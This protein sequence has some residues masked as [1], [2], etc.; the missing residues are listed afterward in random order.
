MSDTRNEWLDRLCTLNAAK[1]A[2]RG[3]APH[4]PLLLLCVM[5]MVEEGALLSPW[6]AYSPELFFR[7]QCYWEI[8]YDRQ[9]NRPDMRLPFHHLGSDRIWTCYE[10]DRSPS[11]SKETTRLCCIDESLW[12]C[13]RDAAFRRDARVRLITAYFTP[14]EQI[15]LCARLRLPEPTTEAIEAI[16][17]TA[18]AYKA[19]QRKGRDSRFRSEVLIS[20]RF[21]CALTG[22]SLNTVN[23]NLVEAAHIHQHAVSGDDD[24]RNGLALTPDA[25]W[26]FDRGLWTSDVSSGEF[27]VLVARG[28]FKDLAPNG[29]SLSDYHEKPLCFPVE[30]ALRPDPKYFDW[31]RQHRFVG[32][33]GS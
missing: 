26:M 28:C 14:T 31:H 33:L 6:L 32:A 27:I 12:A 29:R 24:P 9:R 19:S 15:A 8:V 11:R 30:A 2:A 7:F 23:E 10:D 4:K 16:R 17:R 20:Y 3:V 25:H 18:Q 5:D 1:T 21:T 22:Y 13:L